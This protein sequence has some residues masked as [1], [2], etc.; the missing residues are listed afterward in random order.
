MLPKFSETFHSMTANSCVIQ[1]RLRTS[2]KRGRNRFN[3]SAL[4]RTKALRSNK[5]KSGHFN[6]LKRKKQT[7][8][9]GSNTE[10]YLWKR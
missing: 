10:T 7:E 6:K 8:T 1:V 2:L 4:E 3:I 5:Q 9:F